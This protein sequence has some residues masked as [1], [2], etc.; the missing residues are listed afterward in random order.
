MVSLQG[1]RACIFIG[2]LNGTPA[3]G[4]DISSAYLCAKTSKKVCIK[5]GPEFGS[6]VGRLLI[7]DKTLYGLRL[8][9]KAFNQL[10]T[11]VLHSLGFKPS[12][13]E[14]SV[15]VRPYP[16]PTKDIYEYVASYVD[17]LCYVVSD[18]KKFLAN[19]KDNKVY[20]F[21]LKGSGEFN[22]HLGCGFVQ[23]RTNIMCMD[24][25]R[26][27]D[28][29]WDNYNKL[30]P[31]S[32]IQ[33]RY[34]QPLET[35]DHPELDVTAFCDEDKTEIYQYLI[36]SIQ[37]AVSIGRMDVQI[38]LMTMSSFREKPQVGHLECLKRMVEF[39]A[40]FQDYKICFCTDGPDFSNSMYGGR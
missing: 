2:E 22:F 1:L 34:R 21:D 28:K 7:F 12:R 14:P 13:A 18:P 39:F 6:Q 25:E 26:Y 17:D 31:D 38:A 9:G 20:N 33:K 10:L 40:F 11:D 37:W 16:D 8:S 36:G 19:L 5:A 35:N 27:V 29:M 4:I 30:F 23:D 3:W 32:P 24:A 15:Y